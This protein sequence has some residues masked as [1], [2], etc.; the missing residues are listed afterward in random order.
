VSAVVSAVGP[1]GP[2]ET[3]AA[4]LPVR[5]APAVSA[6]APLA[7]VGRSPPLG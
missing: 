5:S 2:D 4:A 6:A 1:V 3:P 7:P